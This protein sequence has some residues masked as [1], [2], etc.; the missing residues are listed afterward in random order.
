M[1]KKSDKKE[2]TKFNKWQYD[3]LCLLY[4]KNMENLKNG[5]KSS[6]IAVKQI[7]KFLIMV[8]CIILLT[9]NHVQFMYL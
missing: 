6:L 3:T 1:A 9:I 8:E 5:N 2:S 4:G 7:L